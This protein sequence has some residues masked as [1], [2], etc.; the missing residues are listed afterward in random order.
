MDIPST[1]HFLMS[2]KSF[3]KRRLEIL[4]TG[5][6]GV[7]ATLI[8]PSPEKRDDRASSNRVVLLRKHLLDLVEILGGSHTRTG[9]LAV[10]HSSFAGGCTLAAAT[11]SPSKM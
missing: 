8:G 11:S 5:R 10:S 2:L 3:S 6:D 1:G 4:A 7:I 9:L